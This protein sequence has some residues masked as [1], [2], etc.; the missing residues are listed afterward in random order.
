MAT[1][2]KKKDYEEMKIYGVVHH[3]ILFLEIDER[4]PHWMQI[5]MLR[6]QS[7]LRIDEFNSVGGTKSV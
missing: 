1:P 4:H 3:F 6:E 2:V 5:Q 7:L